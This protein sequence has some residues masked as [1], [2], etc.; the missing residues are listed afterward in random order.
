MKESSYNSEETGEFPLD[1]REFLRSSVAAIGAAAFGLKGV[2]VGSSQA[3]PGAKPPNIIF[4]MSDD[5]GWGDLSLNWPATNVRLECGSPSSIP[6]RFAAHPGPVS[7]QVN[8][9]WK[10]ECGEAPAVP[11]P[12]KTITAE[13]NGML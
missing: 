7:S 4:I 2:S 11:D 8:T 12:E 3:E 10:T 1:R 13:S 9:R 5:Q 6:S